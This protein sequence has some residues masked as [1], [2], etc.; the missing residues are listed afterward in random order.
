MKTQLI[1]IALFACLTVIGCSLVQQHKSQ[2]DMDVDACT[3]G[4]QV[5]NNVSPDKREAFVQDVV[6]DC[7][8]GKGYRDAAPQH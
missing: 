2:H 1:A 7:M 6:A 5:P 8:R 3:Y 4:V